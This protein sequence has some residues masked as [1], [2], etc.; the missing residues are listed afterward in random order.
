MAVRRAWFIPLL[1]FLLCANLFPQE[2]HQS[3]SIDESKIE[4]HLF[5]NLAVNIPLTNQSGHTI[6]GTLL[7]EMLA[8]NSNTIVDQTAKDFQIPPGTLIEM[9]NLVQKPLYR[10]PLSLA[11]SRLR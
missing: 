6:Q 9:L 8:W 7:V 2:S 5:P 4:F 3:V 10:D 11:A 1:A